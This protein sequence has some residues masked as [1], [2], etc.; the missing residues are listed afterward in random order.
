[1]IL[2]QST[3][4]ESI[5]TCP[6]LAFN[7]AI[8]GDLSGMVIK[9]KLRKRKALRAYAKVFDEYLKEFGLPREYE[10]YLKTMIWAAEE[11]A[12]AAQGERF[13]FTLAQ[14]KEKEAA[15][16]LAGDSTPLNIVAANLS[17]ALGFPV[18]PATVTV[19]QFYGYLKSLE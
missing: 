7:K 1:M 10:E 11:Y 3:Y 9:G 2:T 5:H 13:R 15:K 19:A 4:Y 14:L 6:I 16:M 17:K 8:T 18:N 12:A